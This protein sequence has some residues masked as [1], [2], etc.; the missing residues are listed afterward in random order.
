MK[1]KDA[2][3]LFQPIVSGFKRYNLTI[4]IV[5]L[6]SGLTTAVLLLNNIL[7]TSSDVSG[8]NANTSNTSFD[9]TT[10]DRVQQLHTSSD[11]FTL[12]IPPAGRNNPFAE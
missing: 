6:V 2:S 11:N 4:F 10:I 5:V 12:Y 8:L 3:S 7:I 9:Q 1:N